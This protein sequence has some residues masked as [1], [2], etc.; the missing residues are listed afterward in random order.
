VLD[1]RQRV[2]I[3]PCAA[4]SLD[5]TLCALVLRQD[6]YL[7]SQPAAG[8]ASVILFSPGYG[9]KLFVAGV[10]PDLIQHEAHELFW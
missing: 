1:V 3:D 10:L 5:G 7:R 2:E 9:L 6:Q 4:R 8:T